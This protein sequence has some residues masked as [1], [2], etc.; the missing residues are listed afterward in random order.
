MATYIALLK[1]TDQ[2]IK[3]IKQSPSRLDAAKQAFASAG[4]QLKAFYMVMGEYDALTIAEFPSDEA[5]AATILSIASRG[6]IQTTT[7]KAFTEDEYR[8]IIGSMP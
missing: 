6:A 8:R 4:G 3:D 5:Y 1:W 2:G 7:L